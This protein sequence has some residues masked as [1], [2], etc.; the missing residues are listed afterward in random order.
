M[1][2]GIG[3][4]Y[5]DHTHDHSSSPGTTWDHIIKANRMKTFQEFDRDGELDMFT[6]WQAESVSNVR[7]NAQK[8]QGAKQARP[9]S[10]CLARM[11]AM[12]LLCLEHECLI[13]QEFPT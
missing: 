10:A 7:P 1:K 2:K 12:L 3:K 11:P 5:Y 8:L 4:D 9:I 13:W 6:Y